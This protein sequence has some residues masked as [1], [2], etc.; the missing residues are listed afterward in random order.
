MVSIG[1]N[2]SW[3]EA[4]VKINE[5]LA[6]PGLV[7]PQGPAGPT[8]AQGP[9]GPAGP[10]GNQGP[11]G[12]KGDE[13]LFASRAAAAARD[14]S[15]YA[16]VLV[17]RWADSA[18]LCPAVYQR[19]GSEPAHPFKF[20]DAAGSW[21]EIGE[22]ETVS[23]F[24]AGAAG[25]GTT[26]DTAAV[27]AAVDLAI[28]R[29]GTVNLDGTFGVSKVVFGGSGGSNPFQ[30]VGDGVLIGVS[31]SPQTCIL[32]ITRGN[33]SVNGRIGVQANRGAAMANYPYGVW[34]HGA[35]VQFA[36]LGKVTATG[37]RTAFRIGDIAMPD[38]II[39]EITINVFSTYSC[40][41][42]F[43]IEGCETYITIDAPQ[44]S[45]DAI[46]G[47][48]AWQAIE[49]RVGVVIGA[50]V[51][52]QGGEAVQTGSGSA[53]DFLWEIQPLVSANDGALVWGSVIVD[54]T[55]TESAGPLCKFSNPNNLTGPTAATVGGRKG[56]F[57]MDG[58]RGF[59]SQNNSPLIV[60]DAG[61]GYNGEIHV[62]GCAMWSPVARTQYDIELNDNNAC[63]VYVDDHGFGENF[64]GPL[65]GV[66]GGIVKFSRRQILMVLGV[67]AGA[68]ASG[69]NVVLFSTAQNDLDL[70]RFSPNYNP[71]NGRYL[72]PAGGLKELTI[73]AQAFYTGG[74]GL[75]IIRENGAQ[76]AQE[77]FVAGQGQVEVDL[78]NVA[79]GNY[80]D[81]VISISS[82]PGGTPSTNYV[83]RLSAVASR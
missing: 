75:I 4:R 27:Q 55:V 79:A 1:R 66:H 16:Q 5:F 24:H 36:D 72:V 35:Q 3:G 25:N 60:A 28:D 17:M 41:R 45:A 77:E 73:K 81:V 13:G 43:Q 8:G 42:V 83:N 58:C 63:V 46:G 62:S 40:P 47:D 15:S 7:G 65:R 20:Q 33:Y 11:V 21:F 2:E 76:I 37:L 38:A 56:L 54:G 67:A 52:V 50:T 26:D 51:L 74:N 23:P 49:K 32:E 70:G 18:R 44:M 29:K 12:P 69:N 9:A 10:Q 48:S 39:S 71:T 57:R 80:Y 14:L 59:H 19:A 30:V 82:S 78:Y 31:G 61:V 34:L 64:F 22:L 53:T 6:Q 68:L